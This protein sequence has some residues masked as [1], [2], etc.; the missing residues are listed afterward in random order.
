[1]VWMRR[2]RNPQIENVI[3]R[4]A[5]RHQNSFS[6]RGLVDW[7]IVGLRRGKVLRLAGLEPD[8]WTCGVQNFGLTLDQGV[9]VIV[10]S[11]TFDVHARHNDSVL[12]F[13]WILV[14]DDLEI[15]IK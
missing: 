14:G 8:K 7:A 1:M 9:G 12:W 13:L 3:G 5:C 2:R 6:L 10:P 15:V 11:A 4:M